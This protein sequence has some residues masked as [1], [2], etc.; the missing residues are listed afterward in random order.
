MN[1]RKPLSEPKFTK[2]TYGKRDYFKSKDVYIFGAG[3]L[4]FQFR[5]F[6]TFQGEIKGK[7]AN[8]GKISGGGWPDGPLGR[9]MKQVGADPIPARKEIT[10]MIRRERDKFFA[11]FY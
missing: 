3:G 10:A 9:I 7:K 5:A 2:V 4:E 1:Y 8:H 6:S 11:M